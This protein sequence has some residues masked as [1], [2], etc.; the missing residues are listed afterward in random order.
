MVTGINMSY[1]DAK[2]NQIL[3]L[4]EGMKCNGMSLY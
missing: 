4:L 2:V 1:N 3:G